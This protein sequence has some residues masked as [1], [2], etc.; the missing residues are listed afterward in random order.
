MSDEIPG[1]NLPSS[2]V[3]PWWL[4]GQDLKAV[5]ASLVLRA[6]ELWR[7]NGSG[8]L[9]RPA[10]WP[11]SWAVLFWPLVLTGAMVLLL[12]IGRLVYGVTTRPG[13]PAPLPVASEVT[14]PAPGPVGA[15]DGEG[16]A[17]PAAAEPGAQQEDQPVDQPL[18]IVQELPQPASPPPPPELALDPLL[19]LL[20]AGEGQPL[21]EAA[22]PRPELGHLELDLDGAGFLALPP[23]QRQRQ[24]DLWQER[25]A[26]LG[27]DGLDLVDGGSLGSGSRLLGRQARVGNGMIL[28]ANG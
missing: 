16:Q 21:I 18:G 11:R 26:E 27:Y 20:R 24:A 9:P 25:A 2:Y 23:A 15:R 6:R 3:S 19:E 17:S 22:R 5:A 14:T 13:L 7:R 4:L 28:L 10:F 1:S 12:V 8:D